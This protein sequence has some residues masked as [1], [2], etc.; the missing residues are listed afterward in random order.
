MD[1][2]YAVNIILQ[3]EGRYSFHPK[4]PGGETNFGISKR[5][6]P[7]IDIKALTKMEATCI[8]KADFWDKYEIEQMDPSI[9]LMFFDCAVNQG[10]TRAKHI[11]TMCQGV[12]YDSPLEMLFKFTNIRLDY[13]MGLPSWTTFGKGWTR[14]LLDI[15][16]LSAKDQSNG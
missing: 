8:Y 3:K 15:F 4:D 6:Y 11:L 9:R 5:S 14:R 16:Y 2:K 7:K 1:F 13:Y 12:T 10:P